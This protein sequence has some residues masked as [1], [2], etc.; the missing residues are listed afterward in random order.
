MKLLEEVLSLQGFVTCV[1]SFAFIVSLKNVFRRPAKNSQKQS[2]QSLLNEIEEEEK[3]EERKE[4]E[5][6]ERNEDEKKEEKARIKPKVYSATQN[7]PMNTHMKFEDSPLRMYD[8]GDLFTAARCIR[9]SLDNNSPTS[10]RSL[11]KDLKSLC[12]MVSKHAKMLEA[13]D[14]RLSMIEEKSLIRQR[15]KHEPSCVEM[16]SSPRHKSGTKPEDKNTM[17]LYIDEASRISKAAEFNVE[18]SR[19]RIDN[20]MREAISNI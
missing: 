7:R 20:V 2:L 15:R 19:N 17:K 11:H 5:K 12:I 1:L 4:D 13:L 10:P 3:I 14:H 8:E 16:L 6:K 9:A 18:L